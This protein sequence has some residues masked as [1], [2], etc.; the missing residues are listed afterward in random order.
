MKIQA[1]VPVFCEAD[2]LPHTLR[3]LHEQ[4]VTIHV[5]DGWSTD[6]SYEIAQL[7]ADS[8]EHFPAGAPDAFNR[9]AQI[10]ERI[11]HLAEDSDADWCLYSDA[12]EWRRAPLPRAT[13]AEAVAAVDEARYSAIDFRVFQF[14]CVN[15][16]WNDLTRFVPESPET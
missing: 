6:G 9:H 8:V 1:F 4:G 7:Q 12:D 3:H 11:E 2:I 15:P 16:H 13:L 14:Y 10:L 5:I